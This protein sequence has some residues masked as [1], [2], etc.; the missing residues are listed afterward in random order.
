MAKKYVVNL[1]ESEKVEL[2]ALTQKGRTSARKIKRANI[3]L[4]ANAGKSDFEIAGFLH[5]SW[6]N[7][8]GVGISVLTEQCL[9]RRMGSQ[10][11]VA[12]EIGA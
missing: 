11:I 2:V 5:S 8:A 12:N 7:M 6:L 10:V 9:D 4:L 3:Q 1:D